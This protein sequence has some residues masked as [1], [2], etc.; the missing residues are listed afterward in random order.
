MSK[1]TTSPE[2][3]KNVKLLGHES[4]NL[5]LPPPPEEK[6]EV[7][8]YDSN[9]IKQLV[10]EFKGLHVQR[11]TCLELDTTLNKEERQQKKV[12]FLWSYANDLVEQNQVLVETVEDLQMEADNKVSCRGMKLHASDPILNVSEAD[13]RTLFLDELVGPAANIPHSS[14]SL[15][16]I[17]SELEDLKIQLQ[18]KDMVICD[19]ERTL[20]E[21]SQQ[22]Q[23]T[24]ESRERLELLQ[25]ELSCLQRIHKDNMKEITERGVCIT[26]LQAASELLR[27]QEGDDTRTQLSKLNERAR[28][29]QEEL[30][31][32][33]EEWRQRENEQ[34]LKY[35]KQHEEAEERGRQEQQ[36]REEEWVRKVDEERKTH[37]QAVGQLAKKADVLKSESAVSRKQVERQQKELSGSRQK[38]E[39][40]L[41]EA[42]A[43]MESLR[44]GLGALFERRM[45][46]KE[47]INNHLTEELN[48]A[49]LK[50]KE[51]EEDVVGLR[52]TQD[53]LK[54]TL[55]LKEKHTQQLLHDNTQLKESLS[56]LQSKLQTTSETL[57][58]T[59]KSLDTEQQQIQKQLHHANKA[60]KHLQ[61]EL[62]H[63]RHTAEKKI[64]KREM[65]TCAL[66]KQLSE[67]QE[68]LLQKDMALEE[69][70]EERE[71]LRAKMEDRSRECV[72]LHQTKERLEA[73]LALSHEKIHTSHLE[74]RSRDQF[75]LQLRAEM[76]TAE[77]KHQREQ[78]PVAVLEG[79]VRH[80][81][82][83][84]R[85]HHEEK[86]QLIEKVRDIERLVDQKEKEQQ[87][88]H[89]QLH[90]GQQQVETF[91]GKLKKQEVETEL[92]H[93]Q[94]RGASLQAQEQKETAAIFRQK[95]TAAMEK[96]HRVQGQ[97]EH[98]EEEL[99]YS[100]HQLRDSKLATDSVR[101]E[102]AEMEQRYQE[103]VNQWENSQEAL[104]QLTDELQANQH[105]L[106][107]S[108]QKEDHLKGL[109]GSMQEQK[110][111]LKQQ[112]HSHSDEEYVHQ[113]K[114][115]QQLQKRCT[116]QVES[117][118]RCEKA[119][120]QMKSELERQ[121]QDKVCLKRSLL[122][123]HHTH[124]I[125]RSQLEQEAI[126]LKNE[127]TRVELELADT[128]KVHVALLRQSEEELKEARREVEVQR[129][130]TQR[131]QEEILKE[132]EKRRSAIREK[133]SLSACVRQLSREMEELRSKQQVT[134]E[135]LA[136][137][138]EEAR[139]MEGCLNEGK[140]A[141]G[142]IRSVAVRLESE[143]L[144]LKRN[145]QQAVDHKLE[146]ERE[147]QEAQEQLKETLIGKENLR[148]ESQ[149]VLT[150]VNRWISE[151][152]SFSCYY[153][154]SN[155]SLSAQMKA[156]NKMLLILTEEKAHLQG[157]N[158]TLKAEVK[159]L[160][161]TVDKKQRDMERFKARI[162]DQGIRQDDR[163]LEKQG[164][165]AQ[166][167]SKMEDMQTRLRS[168]LEAV[169]MLNQQLTSLSRENKQ[170]HRQL[171]EENS[172]RRQVALPP[173]PP[174]QQSSSVHLPPPPPPPLGL[175][176]VTG[177][178]DGILT[179]TKARESSIQSKKMALGVICASR[180]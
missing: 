155:E 147:K 65:K 88:L 19:L 167:L 110:D 2:S 165:V 36:K 93:E 57:D 143:V 103:K 107:E 48:T 42:E 148:C 162:R 106:R 24:L 127:V 60:R 75:I 20:G 128:Q 54:G 161:E 118:A 35:E 82:H 109:I 15:V 159:R 53:S 76:K 151:Q 39:A 129:E 152:R 43:K 174:S 1:K 30:R 108:Q 13:L 38:E 123:S 41:S 95:Y 141:E 56:S 86:F 47:E 146:A 112:S 168:N 28:E 134:E 69:L 59:R 104:D 105:L 9:N 61:Q 58:Q 37:A 175:D 11:L 166:N 34:K 154:A 49:R 92:L 40:L 120:L 67:C 122:A 66:A 68:E 138:A 77:Q 8:I 18:T 22:R 81:K 25:S 173:P 72:H 26:K 71:E 7:S 121:A 5:N 117:L 51:R 101:E 12:N 170:L 27:R 96:V 158:N 178:I 163:T 164:C 55:A 111:A 3:G 73:D 169:G 171:E 136:A 99:Q 90:D 137:R 31:R 113:L 83:K 102:L 4:D 44:G 176:T 125:D 179:Q 32:K 140:L 23:K 150:N 80:L 74:V 119:I 89:E 97:V 70:C 85:G 63:A 172:K 160:K 98:L 139:R 79:E 78:E 131:L 133:Q 17:T 64:Q 21:N 145:L 132:E 115:H 157:A 29:L 50:M 144:E 14:V 156:Q 45:E 10:N 100:Q 62:T 149:L 94:L 130:E 153:R 180:R 33:E 114:H 91:K 126:H 116:E 84:V 46:E 177:D 142:K 16:Q 52:A 135:E 124:V 6:L 87:Q